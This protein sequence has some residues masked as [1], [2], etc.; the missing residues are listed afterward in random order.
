M[1]LGF[2]SNRRQLVLLR[3][4]FLSVTVF[5]ALLYLFLAYL[6]PTSPALIPV[7]I[8]LSRRPLLVV[9]HPDDEALFF[10]PTILGLTQLGEP[11]ELRILVLSSGNNYGLG[12]T[13]KTEL[14]TACERIGAKECIV[15]DRQ[16]IRD[17]P[18][19]WWDGAIVTP[20]VNSWSTKFKA[21]AVSNITFHSVTTLTIFR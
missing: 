20:L 2:R 4:V 8:L 16:D 15:L 6:V 3:L 11:K 21:D 5:P 14:Q 1:R 12:E 18:S 19:L 7:S 9:A 13:R 10:G 17:N